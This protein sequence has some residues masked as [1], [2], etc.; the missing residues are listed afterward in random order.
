MSEIDLSPEL[1]DELVLGDAR[2][3][4]KKSA[5]IQMSVSRELTKADLMALV[6]NAES[7]QQTQNGG[8]ILKIRNA[9]HQLARH[10]A[11]GTKLAEIS[12]LTGYSPPYIS[13]LK[14][15][16]A[17]QELLQYYESQREA[18][19]VDTA[20]R[21]KAVSIAAL[22]ELQERI[23]TQPE[24]FKHRELMELAALAP[25]VGGNSQKGSPQSAAGGG[26]I[27]IT[28]V[29]PEPIAPKMI[30]ISPREED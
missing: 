13:N 20:E 23:D 6:D 1:L 27:T 25:G 8:G 11:L 3:S 26:D 24:S 19:F 30:D 29:T 28:F 15:D 21:A 17:F 2:G 16:P 7:P 5:P 14:N 9:H 22:E 12:A 18:I 4:R 10:L